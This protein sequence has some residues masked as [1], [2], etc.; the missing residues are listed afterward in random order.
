M[1]IYIRGKDRFSIWAPI[2]RIQ[3]RNKV[4][5]FCIEKNCYQSIIQVL[6]ATVVLW[7]L[8]C[9]FNIHK[10]Y[11]HIYVKNMTLNNNKIYYVPFSII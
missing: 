10:R 8:A 5:L 6:L 9:S 11:L 1:Y 7:S 4:F 3:A 2:V